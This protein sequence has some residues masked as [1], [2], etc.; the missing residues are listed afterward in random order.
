V[1]LPF[2]KYI[3]R[4][5]KEDTTEQL[6]AEIDVEEYSKFKMNKSDNSFTFNFAIN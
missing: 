5:E 2:W 3:V 4:I 1:A 6:E